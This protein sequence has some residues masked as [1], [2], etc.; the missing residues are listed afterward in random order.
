[1]APA[2]I[3]TKIYEFVHSPNTEVVQL[4]VSNGETYTSVKFKTVLGA[5]ATLNSDNDGYINCVISGQ[6]VTIYS[7]AGS[8]KLVT[9][10]LFGRK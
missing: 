1:M 10:Q 9:L 5:T 8:D 3:T 6:T 2:T 7:T 4:T